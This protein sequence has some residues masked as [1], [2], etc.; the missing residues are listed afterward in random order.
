MILRILPENVVI[1][2]RA[3]SEK[4]FLEQKGK[5][6]SYVGLSIILFL[7]ALSAWMIYRMFAPQ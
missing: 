4:W 7:W 2:S 5:L 1:D 6:R 3:E